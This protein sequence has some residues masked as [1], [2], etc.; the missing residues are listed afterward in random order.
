MKI[1]PRFM[2]YGVAIGAAAIALILLLWLETLVSRT[3]SAFFYIGI[4]VS[5]WYGGFRLGL[6]TV[7]VSTLAIDYFLMPPQ[8][9]LFPSQPEDAMRL[10]IFIVV[11]LI[12]NLLTS[13][14]L[15]SKQQIKQLSQ[16]LAQENAEQLR[17]V[18]E[19]N[20]DITER[21]KAEATLQQYIREFEDL[22]NNAPCG[23]H[24]LD[25]EGKFI[26]INDTELKWLGYSRD[27][28]LHKQFLDILTG[29]SQQ[30]FQEN[31]PQFKQ[32]G[33]INNLEF[34][35]VHKDGTT[36]WIS[37]N[38]TAIKDEAGQFLM[39]HST[40]FDIS[41]RK[42]S[43]AV[44]EQYK[45]IVSNVKDG[46]VLLNRDYNYQ[47][48]NQT[49]LDWY[50]KTETE[51]LGHSVSEI[52]GQ[53]FFESF[54]Q[55]RIDKCLTGENS[56]YEKWFNYPNR[57]PQ[58]MSVTYTPYREAKG[59]ISGVIVSLR[60]LTR[61]KQAE[62]QLEFQA[63]IARNMAEG[64][65]LVRASDA[66]IVYA[67]PKFEQMFGYGC[68]EL[69]FQHVSILNYA[70]QSISAEDVNQTIRSMVFQ[71][72][73]AT[74]EVHNVKKDGT[75]FWCRATASVFQHPEY[76]D[77]LVAVHQEI[78][79]RKRI[80]DALRQSEEKFRQ[81]AEN[82]QAVFWMTN[83]QTQQILYI[84][85][86]FETIWQRSCQSICQ[87]FS[88]WLNAIHPDDRPLVDLAFQE[89]VKTGKSDTKYRIIRPD[90]SIRWIRDRA[91]PIKN[92][93]GE[94]VRVA[95][96]AED[97]T[98]LQKVEQIK[99]EFISIVSHE[100]RTPLTAIR[101]AMGLLKTGIYDKKPDKFKRMIEIAA[102]DSDR[103]VRLVNDILDLER[104]ESGR[105]VLEKTNCNATDLIEQAVAGVQALAKE[106][107]IKFDVRP[108]NADVWAAADAIIQTLT[109]L[110]G[111]AI[112]FSPAEAMITVSV[113][114]QKDWVLFKI[115]DQGR[116]IPS[117]KLEA[118]FGRF[119]QIDATDSRIK[120][121]TGLGLAICRSI[122]EQHGGQIWAE[123][124]IGVGSTF[125]F[126][127]PK[128]RTSP[129]I[130]GENNDL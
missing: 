61:L 111:N 125:F 110:L 98:E 8:Y 87:S 44:L 127:L 12:I 47:I 22:Y 20:N 7:V 64:V 109:N 24:S 108:S 40:I 30:V 60:D 33:W 117:D 63:V 52:L 90:G 88:A 46:I 79:E 73:E 113:E 62:Q 92:E 126:T 75:P 65:C 128:S 96:L 9:H 59:N 56:Q 1:Y 18:L 68:G 42:C 91:F 93:L 49:Y 103:L 43:A 95:G 51:V 39:S 50:N 86:A 14:F 72:G 23:Y 16:K 85:P 94:I 122:V 120:G 74:Y 130:R 10:G 77:V 82:I 28:I 5:T 26:R 53:Q 124:I 89:Q 67:N 15:K 104:L 38:G 76:G 45:Y 13:H 71:K 58:F 19:I 4:L 83:I 41:D 100:L 84:S 106:Q 29:D 119:Q 81:L 101:A 70:T 105:A 2:S 25:A 116:G 121:G 123:S 36:R 99:T 6:V 31:F 118:I 69:N 78:T 55:P 115:S 17:M 21:K 57:P 35:I 114:Q 34:E 27:E 97:I 129:E 80:E 102:I 32:Q 54:I 107:N 112:K 66:T 48:V 11:G 37:L 3:I